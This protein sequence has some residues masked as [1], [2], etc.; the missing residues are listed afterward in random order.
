MTMSNAPVVDLNGQWVEDAF[1]HLDDHN[2]RKRL[3]RLLRKHGRHDVLRIFMFTVEY[4][5]CEK[6]S[7]AWT[8]E[9][10]PNY[11]KA[12]SNE[13]KA[14]ISAA[15]TDKT[16]TKEAR[17][18]ISAAWT[19]ER[20][21]KQSAAYSDENNPMYGKTFT[22][23]DETK[24]KISAAGKG[25][26]NPR[27]KGGISFEPYCPRFNFQLKEQVRNRDNRI[28]VLC[29]KG[30]IQNGR[31]LS[32]HHID[33]DKMQGCNGKK[34]YLCALCLSCNCKSDTIEKEFLI[35]SN[36]QMLEIER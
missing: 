15:M 19:P 4:G 33:G 27:W 8:G 13:T 16:Q 28:C 17:A 2:Y 29:G 10:N 24:S 30:E 31:R 25:K 7:T 21:A 32:V 11:G 23:T 36:L 3:Y 34:W 6:I 35:V 26:L 5:R 9:N 14:K 12:R 1:Q 18:K 22:H 20:K